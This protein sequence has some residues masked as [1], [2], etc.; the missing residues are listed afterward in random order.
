FQRESHRVHQWLDSA[1]SRLSYWE[2][3]SVSLPSR[4]DTSE[5]QLQRFL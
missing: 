3:E 2:Q 5:N 4:L 1:R